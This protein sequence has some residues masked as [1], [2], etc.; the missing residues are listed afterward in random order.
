LETLENDLYYSLLAINAAYNLETEQLIEAYDSSSKKL[1]SSIKMNGKPADRSRTVYHS[2]NTIRH[3]NKRDDMTKKD[4]KR[5]TLVNV[6]SSDAILRLLRM[7]HDRFVTEFLNQEFNKRNSPPPPPAT[8]TTNA[9]VSDL[10]VKDNIF[11]EEKTPSSLADQPPS[12]SPHGITL[13]D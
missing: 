10:A 13:T 2:K 7:R 8:I 9:D 3:K 1:R 11:P 12:L 5:S 6:P 4:D